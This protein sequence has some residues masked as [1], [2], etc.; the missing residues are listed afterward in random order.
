MP[1]TSVLTSGNHTL[2]CILDVA[3]DANP[4]NDIDAVEIAVRYPFGAVLINEFFHLPDS[5][6]SEFVEL[7][8]L[9]Q[10]NLDH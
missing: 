6:E 5:A 7:I 2:F 9:E 3:Y 1:L 4:E 8:S 10:V